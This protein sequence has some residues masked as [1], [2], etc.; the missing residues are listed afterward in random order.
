M[1]Q[2]QSKKKFLRKFRNT[3][4]SRAYIADG[5]M[6]Y[7]DVFIVHRRDNSQT[8]ET[9]LGGLFIC[10]KGHANMERMEEEINDGEYRSYQHFISNSKWD[11]QELISRLSLDAS[12][13]LKENKK[14]SG[15]PTGYIVD[16]SSHLKKGKESVGV[17]NQYAGVAGKMENCQVAV[18]SS[19][20]NDTRATIINERLFLPKSWTSSEKRCDK[21]KIPE[22]DRIYK[23]KPELALEMID[24][25]I[26]R[27]VEFDWIGGDGL[28]GHNYQLTKGLDERGKLYVLD[29][30]KDERVFLGK[31]N[32]FIPEK[33]KGRGRNTKRLKAE[34]KPCRLDQ[35][36]S[37]LQEA[38]WER[39]KVRKTA[40]GWLKLEVHVVDVWVWNGQ[41]DQARRRTLVISKTQDKKP[42]LRYSFSNGKSD[43]Y[44]NKEYAYFQ[45]QRYWVERTFD[46]SKN[47][48]GMSDYQIR[49]WIG[50]HHH[51]SL[52]M[53]AAL[54][55]LKEKIESELEFPLMSIRDARILI[56]IE[57]FGTK[58]QYDK[59][60]EQMKIR[61]YYRQKD[62]DRYYRYE[63]LWET[64]TKVV[65]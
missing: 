62:I 58:A 50:W 64:K 20:V 30:H 60:L 7:R 53:L 6:H 29:V 41:E 24:A 45:A 42:K 47:E 2:I 35:Y 65:K 31:P 13:I 57:L 32:L 9:Y 37:S 12:N 19:L 23:T 28:Y 25:D 48:L 56:I 33:K 10:E 40:K 49:K 21:A 34:E 27:G 3:R 14:K 54:F 36:S 63:D 59:R 46:D 51:Q 52:V 22:Q 61:H 38:D 18:Y 11:Y 44:T 5:L 8:A 39:V 43:E 4:L 15:V 55:L 26:E 16:E 1:T 17:S